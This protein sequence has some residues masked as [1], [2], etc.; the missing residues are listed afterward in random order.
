MGI[1]QIPFF[2]GECYCGSVTAI[3]RVIAQRKPTNADGR[4]VAAR[5]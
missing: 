2:F 5:N 3:V 1:A 4:V